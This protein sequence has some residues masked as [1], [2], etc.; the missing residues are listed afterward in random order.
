MQEVHGSNKQVD[1]R[2]RE[3]AVSLMKFRSF[4]YPVISH[5]LQCGFLAT[6]FFSSKL[7]IFLM[8]GEN[9][10]LENIRLTLYR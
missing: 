2:D 3:A 10:L 5:L 4:S 7:N 9:L 1:Y 6:I 8:P